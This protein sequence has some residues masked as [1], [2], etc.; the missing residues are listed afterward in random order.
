MSTSTQENDHNADALPVED[1]DD[2]ALKRRPS[3]HWRALARLWSAL[4]LL[5]GLGLSL[6][7]QHQQWR[8]AQA[9]QWSE[10]DELANKV[11]AGLQ[12]QL[13]MLETLMRATQSLYLASQSVEPRE[14][15]DFYRNMRPRQ[16][17]PALLALAYAQKLQRA[18]GVH[19]IVRLAQPLARNEA[20]IG[21][22]KA[23]QKA[24]LAG[25][26]QA[27]DSDQV[28]MSAPFRLVQPSHG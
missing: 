28:V 4:A 11:Y 27:R 10:R 5:L 21:L 13:Q 12:N 22:D 26:L 2:V 14:F 19:Y 18:D 1:T 8:W 25:L 24:N 17:F 20:L 15:A 23:T 6:L 3:P 9:E 7:V 16:N